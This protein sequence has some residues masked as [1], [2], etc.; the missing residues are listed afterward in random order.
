MAKNGTTT[1]PT[2]TTTPPLKTTSFGRQECSVS[3]EKILYNNKEWA[4]QMRQRDPDFFSRL[5]NIQTPEWLWIGCADSRVPANELLGLGPGT[6]FVQRNVGNLCTHKD[7]NCMACVEYAVS[8]LKVKHIIVTGHY[9]CGAVQA[10]LTLPCKTPGL[11]NLW[12]NDIRDT[13]NH[14]QELLKKLKDEPSKQ[15]DMLV[16]LNVIRQVFNVC[17]CPIVQAAWDAGQPL[18][19]HGLVYDVKDGV[20]KEI[21]EPITS[22]D[23]LQHYLEAPQEHEAVAQLSRSLSVH[24][25]FENSI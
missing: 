14:H 21:T 9:G 1:T 25:S 24:L 17:T 23:D 18:S 16:E 10:A 2:S 15:W 22:M 8:V 7:M 11:V 3:L 5:A 20:L 6:V 19:V 13:R 4:A 12:I